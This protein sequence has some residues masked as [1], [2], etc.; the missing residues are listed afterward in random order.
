M[1]ELTNKEKIDEF[2]RE[3]GRMV[4]HEARVYFTGGST[5]VLRGWRDTTIDIDLRFNPELDEIFRALPDLKEKLHVNIE[6]ASPP[7]FI[8]EVPGWEGRSIHIRREGK[9]DF[10]H[11]D[12]YS[13][14]LAKLE[15]GHSKDL[16][17]VEMMV[18]DRVIEQQRLLSL[19]KEIEPDLYRYPAIHPASFSNAVL[20]FVEQAKS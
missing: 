11:F 7:D 19:F 4:R 12:P 18:R 10:Y 8:P 20:R 1:R 5:A 17:D 15:R 2:M 13:Q 6:L 16:S 9:V 14:A 3:L